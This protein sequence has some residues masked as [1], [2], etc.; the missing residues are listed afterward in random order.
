M[1]HCFQRNEGAA[2]GG[3]P[4]GRLIKEGDP[5]APV[6]LNVGKRAGCVEGTR[7]GFGARSVDQDESTRI[8]FVHLE[9]ADQ[10]RPRASKIGRR[11]QNRKVWAYP[12][13]RP[14]ALNFQPWLN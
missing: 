5:F 11:V 2:N 13:E 14:R 3:G 4:F 1:D 10:C 7:R 8:V 12:S 9:V 6:F